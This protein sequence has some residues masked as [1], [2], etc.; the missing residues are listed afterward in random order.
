[1]RG[2]TDDADTL[3]DLRREAAEERKCA[4]FVCP[5]CGVRGGHLTNC[6]ENQDDEDDTDTDTE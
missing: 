5:E 1:M 4:N 3:A 6:P 2:N